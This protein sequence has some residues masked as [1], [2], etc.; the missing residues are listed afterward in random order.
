MTEQNLPADLARTRVRVFERCSS[1]DVV[2]QP[3]TVTDRAR[4]QDPTDPRSTRTDRA[5][6]PR[7]PRH[8][9][10]CIMLCCN[11]MYVVNPGNIFGWV[12]ESKYDIPRP[13]PDPRRTGSQEQGSDII[14]PTTKSN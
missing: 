7:S 12:P 6:R 9:R 13:H 14:E 2:F 11:I 4:D 8:L 5:R 10:R 1:G 3:A